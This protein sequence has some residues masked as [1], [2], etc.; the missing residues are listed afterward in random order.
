M[1]GLADQTVPVPGIGEVPAY[2]VGAAFVLVCLAIADGDA[3]L[4]DG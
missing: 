2:E 3:D 1:T 4:P